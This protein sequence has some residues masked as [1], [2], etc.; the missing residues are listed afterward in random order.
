MVVVEAVEAVFVLGIEKVRNAKSHLLLFI[1]VC[2][3]HGKTSL[4]TPPPFT[5]PVIS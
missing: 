2:L 1:Q 4:Y 5:F 3:L